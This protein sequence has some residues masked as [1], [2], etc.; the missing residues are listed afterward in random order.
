MKRLAKLG[1]GS[2]NTGNTSP[3][4]A[5]NGDA[6][7]PATTP[8]DATSPAVLTPKTE[9]T[10]ADGEN[11]F[12]QLGMK[13]G[14]E[15]KKTAPQIKVNPR[16]A[17][18][19]KRERDGSEKPRSRP[20]EN[21]ETWQ[22]RN[23]RQIFRVTLKPEDSKDTSG[24]ELIFLA[25]TRQDLIDGDAAVQLNTEVLEG[26]ITE[27]ASQAPGGKP[28]E[29]LLGCFK[30]ASR[31]LR[32]TKKEEEAKREILSETRRLCMSYCVFAVTMPEMFGE[33]IPMSN[34]LVDHLLADP[35][36]DSGICTDFLTEAS[37]RFEED[38][39]I[40]EAIVGAAE[41]L[42]RQLSEKNMLEDY[43]NY[44][45][46]LHNLLR[47]PKIVDAVTQSPL[48]I[49]DG[50]EAQDIETKTL[51]GPFFHLSPM[52][53]E[54]AQSYFS[55][56]KTRDRTYISNAQN[57]VQI[58]LKAHQRELFQMADTIVRSGAAQ[59]ERL[60]NW[61]ALC[62]NMN[63]KK[64]AMRVNF[65]IVSSDGFMV[66]VTSVLDQLC[67][68][69]MDATFGKIDRIHV[70]Y[71]RRNPRVDISD[72]TKINVDQKAADEFYGNKLEGTENFISE[73]FFLT[74]AAHHYGTEAA[75]TR[76]STL[77]KTAQRM[78]KDLEAFQAD[79][80]KYINVNGQDFLLPSI[81]LMGTGRPLLGPLRPTRREGQERDR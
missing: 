43:A 17:S 67:E 65:K 56:P 21:L 53:P 29:Y 7:A 22:D 42:S 79:R 68:P 4:P 61:F 73:V 31:M 49:P 48:W 50:V 35:D 20:Q 8:S 1:G 71:L 63:H 59:R 34:S 19:A 16:P 55:A 80:E 58:T 77:R 46:A 24:H 26:A 18:P 3:A 78:E 15:E 41:E 10:S 28:F 37:T 75:Q 69:F 38:E 64:R 39:T 12:S 74:V 5:A 14:Q 13:G 66:N 81:I 33:D 52:Q 9:S 54:V 2:S 27:A 76:M 30:R 72:E 70:E 36:C 44:I 57:A 51:L 47:F 6:S 11:P 60:L 23:L 45:R 40:K 62:V 32:N 25:S